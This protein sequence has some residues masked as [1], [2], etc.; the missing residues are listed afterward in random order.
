M[1][2]L[3]A[4]L[5][6]IYNRT[7][8]KNSNLV[9]RAILDTPPI[10]TDPDS[11][12][13]V[14]TLLNKENYRA[15]LLAVKSFLQYCPPIRVVVQNDGT[16]DQ[17]SLSD[18]RKHLPGIEIL[19]PQE[20]MAGVRARANPELLQLLDYD[21]TCDFFVRLRFMN[22]VGKYPGKKVIIFDSD[23]VFLRK[24]EYVVQWIQNEHDHSAFHSDGGSF[25]TAGFHALDLD[26]SKVDIGRF[27][28]GFTGFYN[29]L[30]YDYVRDIVSVICRGNPKLMHEYEIEQSLWSVVFNSFDPVACL[31]DVIKDYVASGYWTYERMQK[32]VLVHFVGSVRFKNLRYMRVARKV[33]RQL[34][35]GAPHA[36][37]VS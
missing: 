20:T 26:F 15:Y 4:L 1:G 5:Y 28:A 17:R 7:L 33:I 31:D 12:T 23:L 30:T 9:F 32:S 6:K 37:A 29:T 19:D 35:A 3:K 25:Q 10:E 13:L 11:D 24:P 34:N 18:L 22:V 21:R 14:Y 16:F 2:R 36:L 27:N 8:Q